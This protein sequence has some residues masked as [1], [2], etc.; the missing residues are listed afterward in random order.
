M[1]VGTFLPALTEAWKD[2]ERALCTVYTSKPD[3]LGEADK[4]LEHTL[5]QRVKT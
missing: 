2:W 3:D 5:K 4:F 1:R